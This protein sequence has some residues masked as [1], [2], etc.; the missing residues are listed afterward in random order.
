[1]LPYWILFG[2][3][4]LGA[5]L[6]PLNPAAAKLSGGVATESAGRIPFRPFFLVGAIGMITLIG[7]RYKV[8]ADWDAYI[9]IFSSARGR[10]FASAIQLGDPG[11]MALNWMAQQA[12][13]KIW[14]VNLLSAAIFGWGVFRFATTQPSPWVSLALA[15]P[16]L[17]IVVA[18]GYTRQAVALGILMAGI[19][20][21]VQ[22]RSS[23]LRFAVYVAAAGM[24]HRTAIVVFPLIA[25]SAQRSRVINALIVLSLGVLLYNSFVSDA[26]D[27]YVR[28]YLDTAYGS[29]GAVIRIAMNL[30][31]AALL[32]AYRERL[33]FSEHEW[34]IWRNFSLAA[35]ASAIALSVSPSSTAVDRLS[36]YLIPL[37]IA[38]LTRVALVGGGPLLGGAVILGYAAAVQFVWLN[39]GQWSR[40]WLPYQLFPF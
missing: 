18:M 29:Q 25:I 35:V 19:A 14:L 26:M 28:N 27:T 15:V 10:D 34:K 1:M 21:L 33:G 8:G 7:L 6:S 17:V 38:V 36:L 24:F 22:G 31:P 40:Y 13:A 32:W 12:G 20:S 4:A 16:Y 11:Y 39:F 9:Y 3:F 23:I 2:Y 37:Q 30:V 5:I